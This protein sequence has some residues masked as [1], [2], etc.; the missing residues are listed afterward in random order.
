MSDALSVIRGQID[1]A[2]DELR[3]YAPAAMD[4][5][6]RCLA[7][8]DRVI[9]WLTKF[10]PELLGFC[11]EVYNAP[12]KV[13]DLWTK[14]KADNGAGKGAEDIDLF[15][16]REQ[17]LIKEI[18]GDV[19]SRVM[20]DYMIA[21]GVGKLLASNGKSDYPDLYFTDLD[22]SGLSRFDRK[23]KREYGAALKGEKRKPVRV[24]DGVEIKTCRNSFHVDCHY[25]HM[26]LHVALFYIEKNG[27]AKM[28]DLTAAF[29]RRGD[30]RI[31]Q[32]N[33]GTTTVKAS[34]G[35]K[36]FVSLTPGGCAP[37]VIKGPK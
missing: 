13:R 16:A 8:A 4:W 14:Y 17:V 37:G 10:S 1:A 12:E 25:A 5:H 36:Q 3:E 32:I 28:C 31:S 23:E 20:T 11:E 34:F 27:K 18:A 6:E 22:Y 19:V 21:D 30:Y 15:L 33:T 26:G 29:L 9:P 35:S 2:R 7:T 24:P